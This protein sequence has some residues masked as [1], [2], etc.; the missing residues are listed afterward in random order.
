MANNA[1]LDVFSVKELRQRIVF[2]L[3]I[4]VIFRLGVTLPIP[5]ININALKMYFMSQQGSSNIGITE[6]IDFLPGVH[7]N[8]SLFLCWVLCPIFPPRL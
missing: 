1:F 7:L 6:Y 8:T 5:G 4:L 3:M 2:T